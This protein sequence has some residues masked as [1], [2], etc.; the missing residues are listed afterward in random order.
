VTPFST[1]TVE[2]WIEA[3]QWAE[4][5]ARIARDSVTSTKDKIYFETYRQSFEK[6][7]EEFQK[8]LKILYK[9]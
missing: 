6:M 5:N 1:K 2:E 3:L 7:R 4:E 8:N 9:D